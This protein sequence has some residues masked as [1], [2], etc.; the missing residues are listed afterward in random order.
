[1]RDQLAGLLRFSEIWNFELEG[2][3]L[4]Q[5]TLFTKRVVLSDIN[6]QSRYISFVIL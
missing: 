5:V 3:L 6:V 4:A 2:N 1:M